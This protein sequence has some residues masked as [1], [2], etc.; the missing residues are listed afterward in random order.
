MVLVLVA[1]VFATASCDKSYTIEE[2]DAMIAQLNDAI[3]ANK[4]EHDAKIAALE[5]DCKA[6]NDALAAE[7]AANKLALVE[8][9]S[10]YSENLARLNKVDEDNKALIDN[11]TSEYN[12]KVAELEA[13]DALTD[14]ALADLTSKYEADLA[15]LDK[16]TAENKAKIEALEQTYNARV[17]LIEASITAANS[18]IDANKEELESSITTLKNTYNER[19]S[20]INNLIAEIQ[21]TDAAQNDRIDELAAKVDALLSKHEHTYGQ[22]IR[23]DDDSVSCEEVIFYRVCT[24]CFV[25]ELKHGSY[26]EHKLY[27]ETVAPTCTAQ[28]YD[29]TRCAYCKLC[30]VFNYTEIVE[31][32]WNTAYS[33]D[34]FEHWLNCKDCSARMGSEDHSFNGASNCAVCG[35]DNTDVIAA[36]ENA[37]ESFN[38]T[39]SGKSKYTLVDYDVPASFVYNNRTY[40]VTWTTSDG[41]IGVKDGTS[42]EVYTIDVPNTLTEAIDYEITAIISDS[43]GN[44]YQLSYDRYIPYNLGTTHELKEGVAYKLYA[45]FDY[46]ELDRYVFFDNESGSIKCVS[47]PISANDFYVEVVDGGVKIYTLSDN[48]RLY[49][50]A[51]FST[52]YGTTYYGLYWSKEDGSVFHYAPETN[53]WQTVFNGDS[54]LIYAYYDGSVSISSA[55][56]ISA[57]NLGYYTSPVEFRPSKYEGVTIPDADSTLSIAEANALAVSV[58]YP[59]VNKYYVTGTI[60]EIVSTSGVFYITD[61]AGNKLYIYRSYNA[62][63][64]IVF[65][66]IYPQPKVGDVVTVYGSIGVYNNTPELLD[67]WITII[68]GES[69]L[70]EVPEENSTLT[71]PQANEVGFEFGINGYTTGKYYVSGTVSEILNATYG[72]FYITDDEGNSFYVYGAYNAIGYVRYD[73]MSPQ[74]KV[75]DVVVI[76]GIIGNV[77]N[78][79]CMKNAWI[80]TV[81]GE[82]T[83]FEIPEANSTLTIPQASQ[84][85]MEF[86]SNT[87]T[88]DKY[89]VT[90]TIKTVSNSTWGNLYIVD[91]AGNTLFVYGMYNADGSE[92]YDVMSPRPQVGDVV[93]IYGVIGSYNSSPQMKDAWLVSINGVSTLP[94]EAPEEPSVN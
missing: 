11:L 33:Y 64:S 85:G 31:H 66:N 25:I 61:D 28:G 5:A 36:I 56:G 94:D 53:S 49:V 35:C 73:A 7:I 24:I 74:P 62:D 38:Y 21:N 2:S 71:I 6:K 60:S 51:H 80:I 68:N 89:Y 92:R 88:Q 46:K 55:K 13:A 93:I 44:T 82:S 69:T 50:Y 77:S 17:E 41:R 59:T 4:A 39:Y 43:Y 70:P 48:V 27:T 47:N 75:G 57:E 8:L 16:A 34:G 20:E 84:L 83:T 37:V 14:K 91:D 87:F 19:I 90:G 10:E 18:K 58:I 76:Y 30:T 79:V 23:T 1:T 72:Y 42:S 65:Y 45:H 22:W 78:E 15:L 52:S 40:T 32:D 81:N 3:N 29:I 63:G 12:N 26:S 67:G 9:R 86:S 54:Y